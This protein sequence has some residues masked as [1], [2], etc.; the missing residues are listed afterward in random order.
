VFP[1]PNGGPHSPRDLST[2]WALEA[3]RLGLGAV[4]FHALR[5]SHASQLIDAGVDIVTISRRLGHA[6][7]N[8]TLAIYAHLFRK[9]D[10]KA[11]QAINA[12]LAGLSA[13]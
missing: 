5:H 9:S 13:S 3:D 12:A 1:A 4:T 11:A 2:Q 7:P 10:D 6:T 8:V